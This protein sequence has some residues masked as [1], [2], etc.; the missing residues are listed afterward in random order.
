MNIGYLDA[1]HLQ[2]SPV[3][4]MS[5][6]LFVFDSSFAAVGGSVLVVGYILIYFGRILFR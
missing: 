1:I 5:T 2:T 3:P 4:R 6:T